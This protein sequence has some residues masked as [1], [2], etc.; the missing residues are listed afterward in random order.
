M[1]DEPV[2]ADADD[3]REWATFDTLLDITVNL[4]PLA[5]L[6]FFIGLYTVVSPWEWDAG[7]FVLMHLLTV[8]PFVLLAIL[9]YVSARAIAGDETGE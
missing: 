2:R 5:I 7:M 1:V 8:I 9:T 4:I 6:L 3:T